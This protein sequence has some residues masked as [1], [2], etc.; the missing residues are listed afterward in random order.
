MGT[1][2]ESQHRRDNA[3]KFAPMGPAPESDRTLEIPR[4]ED[5][6]KI[7]VAEPLPNAMSHSQ[8]IDDAEKTSDP[9][10]DSETPEGHFGVVAKNVGGVQTYWFKGEIGQDDA[11]VVARTQLTQYGALHYLNPG[12]LG[13][14]YEHQRLR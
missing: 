9:F 3:G 8:I 10:V 5:S 7:L 12:I 11:P 14:T 6:G 1:F 4:E 13:G 2:S